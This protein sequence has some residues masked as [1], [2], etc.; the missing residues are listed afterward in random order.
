MHTFLRKI[1]AYVFFDQFILL[2]TA[3]SLLFQDTGL[4]PMQIGLLFGILPVTTVLLEVPTGVLADTYSRRNILCCAQLLRAVGY[5]LWLVVGTYAGFAAGFLLWGVSL[6]LVS[7]TFESYVYDELKQFGREREYERIHGKID[8]SR[9][10][11]LTLATFLGGFIAEYGY[12]Y[13][14]W[15]SVVAPVIAGGII[16][17]TKSVHAVRSTQERTYW[18]VLLDAAKEAGGN[19]HLLGI[20]AFFAVVFGVIEASNEYWA[21][22]FRER[23]VTVSSVGVILAASNAA[24]ALAGLTVGRWTI[25]ERGVYLLVL[26]AGLA[27]IFL[28]F[29]SVPAAVALSLVFCYL[30]QV[31]LIKYEARLQHAVSSHQRAT[32]TSMKSLL[33]QAFSFAYFL[34][35]GVLA[36]DYGYASFFVLLGGVIGGISLLYLLGSAR[37]FK[38][39]AITAKKAQESQ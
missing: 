23:G 28:T 21:L 36:R 34:A 6:T 22:Y 13:V 16:L 1:Y 9:F 14:L 18:R 30:S 4:S 19:P 11:G 27:A 3:Y 32:V 26:V 35:L 7:G 10:L 5:A 2:Y 39:V 33:A 29:L 38:A 17:S 15:P 12:A 37:V 25:G 24:T 8:A 31:G 20:I